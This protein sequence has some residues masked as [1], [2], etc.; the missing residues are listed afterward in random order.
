[1]KTELQK[2]SQREN[3][4]PGLLAKGLRYKEIAD[5]LSLTPKL[6]ERIFETS[7]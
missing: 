6:F 5:Q 4:I 2:L 7:T 3:E 1:M